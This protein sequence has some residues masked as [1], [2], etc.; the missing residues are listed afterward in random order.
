MYEEPSGEGSRTSLPP[1]GCRLD[2]ATSTVQPLKQ[3]KGNLPAPVTLPQ[4][5][6]EPV[7]S[8]SN[9][10]SSTNRRSHEPSTVDY[11]RC[12]PI[13]VDT[14]PPDSVH[15]APFHH[16]LRKHHSPSRIA[17]KSFAKEDSHV[18]RQDL[19]LPD[20]EPGHHDRLFFNALRE[21]RSKVPS[22]APVLGST[23]PTNPLKRRRP[24]TTRFDC[25][26]RPYSSSVTSNS[27]VPRP[28]PLLDAVDDSIAMPVPNLPPTTVEKKQESSMKQT[29]PSARH[30]PSEGILAPSSG[31]R[32]LLPP[33][34]DMSCLKPTDASGALSGSHDFNDGS[35]GHSYHQ[36]TLPT[37][38]KEG[39]LYF[40]NN[41]GVKEA[42]NS[43]VNPTTSTTTRGCKFYDL[44]LHDN[45][46]LTNLAV[47]VDLPKQLSALTQQY[48]EEYP[49]S[50]PQLPKAFGPPK[51]KGLFEDRHSISTESDVLRFMEKEIVNVCS[52]VASTLLFKLKT[53]TNVFAFLGSKTKTGAAAD[54]VLGLAGGDKGP[55]RR[56]SSP[57]PY[58][59][60]ASAQIRQTVSWDLHRFMHWEAKSIT[61]GALRVMQAIVALAGQGQEF[62]YEAC[63]EQNQ[64]CTNGEHHWERSSYEFITVTGRPPSWDADGY[65]WEDPDAS[66]F[67]DTA[68]NRGIIS[69]IPWEQVGEGARTSARNI[70]Q[71][72]WAQAVRNDTTIFEI[73]SGVYTI[74]CVRSRNG[75]SL[76]VS[77]V[78]RVAH[79]RGYAKLIIGMF[80][81]AF[82][83]ALARSEISDKRL[84]NIEP[85]PLFSFPFFGETIW[86]PPKLD[87]R[88][89][90]ELPPCKTSKSAREEKEEIRLN[91]K[92]AFQALGS[93]DRVTIVCQDPSLRSRFRYLGH[94]G[95]ENVTLALNRFQT[96]SNA[97]SQPTI[98][99]IIPP[100]NSDHKK[101]PGAENSFWAR[102]KWIAPNGT[103]HVSST[104]VVVKFSR[105]LLNQIFELQ[106]I[107]RE[108]KAL[109]R[110][111]SEHS[112]WVYGLFTAPG[113]TKS[114]AVMVT[115]H[116]GVSVRRKYTQK[117]GKYNVPDEVWQH[118]RNC[119]GDAHSKGILYGFLEGPSPDHLLYNGTRAVIIGWSHAVFQPEEEGD[120][121]PK[122]T[123]ITSEV[124]IPRLSMTPEQFASRKILEMMQLKDAIDPQEDGVGSFQDADGDTASGDPSRFEEIEE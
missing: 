91:D 73:F 6:T 36:A 111:Q 85:P 12:Q 100:Q 97:T 8:G 67:I 48:F 60:E 51:T 47:N 54:G 56:L 102:L 52:T 119:L 81:G 96:K 16:D 63:S 5:T 50:Y 33:T 99:L 108:Y 15:S 80:I 82:K 121:I 123:K 88:L 23:T 39:V 62:Q 10:L 20:S 49:H 110:L 95:Q 105:P 124:H 94:S 19:S 11:D 116:G 114:V 1:A 45:L 65:A 30:E 32:S 64:Q 69:P 58:A 57:C 107:F 89:N 9:P 44:H 24:D 26:T 98:R 77:P 101:L 79:F 68:E 103:S 7:S 78:I 42:Q 75:S 70:L 25:S 55:Y 21:D 120:V 37:N 106:S 59:T 117:D 53:W 84:A 31:I 109:S 76:T 18:I 34:E 41:W 13:A 86:C 22:P 92:H 61:A 17:G 113:K 104:L 74:I 4:A 2:P 40:L 66:K 90:G 122:K 43:T 29:P 72:A 115:E 118:L 28:V 27:F 71:Q 46:R 38:S 112:H 14:S 3:I 87:G 93:S 35:F 83:D